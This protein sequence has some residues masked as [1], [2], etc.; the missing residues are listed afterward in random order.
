M[1]RL[2]HK[3][4]FLLSDVVLMGLL[5][6]ALIPAGL[7][8]TIG[9]DGVFK[10]VLCSASGAERSVLWSAET[11]VLD[12]DPDGTDSG[13]GPCAFSAAQG[14]FKSTPPLKFFVNSTADASSIPYLFRARRI[15]IYRKSGARDPPVGI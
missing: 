4:W 9:Q 5:L 14:D 12:H 11:G 13:K 6:Q 1:L 15:D 3:K 7:M 8:P 2:V 10:L